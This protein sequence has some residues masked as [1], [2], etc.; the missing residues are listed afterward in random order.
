MKKLTVLFLAIFFIAGCA[1]K[2]VNIYIPVSNIQ[3]ESKI[4]VYDKRENNSVIGYIYSKGEIIADIT[5]SSNVS[6]IV[7]NELA[8]RGLEKEAKI[9]IEK[10]FI[11]YDKS[12][13]TGE[14][15][16]GRFVAK[17]VVYK[18]GVTVTKIVK[19]DEAKWINP[20]KSSQELSEFAKKII[21]EGVR[22]VIK[23]IAE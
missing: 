4:K 14:N 10:L 12:K 11:T 7:K 1:S 19:I 16:K 13:L 18:K 5:I 2:G 17:V 20:I 6:D 9:Y 23:A 3:N 21:F 15:V 8:K 22:L